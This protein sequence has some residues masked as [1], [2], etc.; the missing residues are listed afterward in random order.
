M[1]KILTASFLLLGLHL[2]GVSGQ[3]E[4]RDQQ[5]EPGSP[6][7]SFHLTIGPWLLY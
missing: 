1:D 6:A 5:Q 3:Q 2:A 7:Y 4:K